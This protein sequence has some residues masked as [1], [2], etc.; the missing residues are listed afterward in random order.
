MLKSGNMMYA[1]NLHPL[2]LQSCRC[3]KCDDEVQLEQSKRLQESVDIIRKQAGLPQSETGWSL[4]PSSC[5][6][7]PPCPP[8]TLPSPLIPPPL[9]FLL[10]LLLL[11]LPL[12]FLLLLLLLF[13]LLLLLLFLLLLLLLLLKLSGFFAYW[14][15]IS[16]SLASLF[17]SL[18]LF[19]KYILCFYWI[20]ILF[21]F[22][23][24]KQCQTI[25]SSSV[26]DQAFKPSTL[27]PRSS[28]LCSKVKVRCY[29][30]MYMYNMA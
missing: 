20:M 6:P 16:S 14:I 11:L 25:S 15:M 26:V 27:T 30:Y 2:F 7:H 1:I 13:L 4:P 17:S 29:K 8:L 18:S 23:V 9:T 24:R 3:Y 12:L 21:Y 22:L 28:G 10:L 19:F 5:P